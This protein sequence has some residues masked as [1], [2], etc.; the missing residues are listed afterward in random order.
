MDGILGV[1]EREGCIEEDVI[2][3]FASFMIYCHNQ[4]FLILPCNITQDMS[5]FPRIV[6]W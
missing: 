3:K 1:G 5:L 2:S 6:E 4:L